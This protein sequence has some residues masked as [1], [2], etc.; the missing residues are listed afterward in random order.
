LGGKLRIYSQIPKGEIHIQKIKNKNSKPYKIK[1]CIFNTNNE[2][3]LII[4]RKEYARFLT[5]NPDCLT[6]KRSRG[7]GGIRKTTS[8]KMEDVKLIFPKNQ[9]L[10]FETFLYVHNGPDESYF[11]IPKDCTGFYL[12]SG[13]DN[14]R[15]SIVWC[16]KKIEEKI[17][18]CKDCSLPNNCFGIMESQ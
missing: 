3:P 15:N 17:E 7:K 4:S 8:Q 18:N 13:K 9:E 12:I 5:S 14:N 1:K 11:G 16:I 2:F 10:N 6:V